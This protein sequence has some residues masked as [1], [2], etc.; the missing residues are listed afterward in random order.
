MEVNALI[1][2]ALKKSI[3]GLQLR[4]YNKLEVCK[5]NLNS[6]RRIR[7]FQVPSVLNTHKHIQ[8]INSERVF[9]KC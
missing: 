3:K 5:S 6:F 9:I 7:K 8:K 4:K 2:Q 1:L